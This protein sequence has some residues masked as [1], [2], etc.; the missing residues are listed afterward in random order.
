MIPNKTR[1]LLYLSSL[2]AYPGVPHAGGVTIWNML[3][4]L[5]RINNVSWVAFE[6]AMEVS[7][8]DVIRGTVEWYSPIPAFRGWISRSVRFPL[9]LIMPLDMVSVLSLSF[10]LEFRRVFL[11]MSPD[12]VQAEYSSMGIY[13]WGLP[14]S[15]TSV[16]NLHDVQTAAL[17]Q[18][19]K[20]AKGILRPILGWQKSMTE[21][22]EKKICRRVSLI[23]VWSENDREFLS[24]RWHI[25]KSKIHLFSPF[26][27]FSMENIPPGDGDGRT[28]LFVGA[29][30]RK[31][32]REGCE[33]FLEKIWPRIKT[34]HPDTVFRI[35]GG[36]PPSHFV[37]KWN[38]LEG[39]QIAG[40]VSDLSS[41]YRR[42]TV[43]VVPLLRAGGII[44]KV[45]DALIAGRP[46]VATTVANSGILAKDY[47]IRVA[48]DPESFAE[49]VIQLLGS[50]ELC[51]ESGLRGRE[52]VLR[53]YRWEKT[54]EDLENAYTEAIKRRSDMPDA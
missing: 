43:V 22:W 26:V 18:A 46:V 24:H 33:W 13:F 45:L 9:L 2:S 32:N 6:K 21:W 38:R 8:R 34:L 20:R 49:H 37:E 47:E 31:V 4:S 36:N 53:R 35:I 48:D 16:L 23:L 25:P 28:L 7:K 41:E 42:A 10:F 54:M 5:S 30:D 29:M 11:S 52:F 3:S 40:Y 27:D 51:R 17:E 19:W 15:A 1:S 50:P 14:R 39:V 44:V 12:I